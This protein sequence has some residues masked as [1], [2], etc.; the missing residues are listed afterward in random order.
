MVLAHQ[1]LPP[2][3]PLLHP[4]GG[5]TLIEVVLFIL[6]AGLVLGGIVAPFLTSLSRLEQPEIVAGAIFLAREKLEELT[7]STYSNIQNESR[8]SLGGNYA[9]FEREV[10][11]EFVQPVGNT[12]TASASDVGY[13]R[14][15]VTVYHAQLP[16]S[17]ISLTSLFTDYEG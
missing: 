3:R 9:A 7:A 14:V 11:V 17:G 8:G 6:L 12:L 10:Q 5:F 16:A 1:G 4:V 15:T 2:H 13:K